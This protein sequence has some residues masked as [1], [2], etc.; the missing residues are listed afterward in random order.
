VTANERGRVDRSRG[1]EAPDRATGG[2]GH[3]Q[4]RHLNGPPVQGGFRYGDPFNWL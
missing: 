4:A 2:G 3:F 1:P